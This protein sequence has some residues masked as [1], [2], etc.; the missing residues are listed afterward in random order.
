MSV[1]R[2]ISGII[3]A[4]ADLQTQKGEFSKMAKEPKKPSEERDEEEARTRLKTL[5]YLRAI[6][7]VY[8]RV[9]NG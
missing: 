6:H 5:P 7:S 2:R 9:A 1:L 4:S 8:R 3:R